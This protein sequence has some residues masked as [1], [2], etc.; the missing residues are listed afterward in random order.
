M[1]ITKSQQLL[2][3]VVTE[4]WENADFKKK[5][6]ADPVNAIEELTGEKL[7]IPEGKTFVVKDQTD[8]STVYI[9]IPAEQKM[10][11]VE[12]NDAQLEAVAGGF[13]GGPN[14]ETCTAPNPFNTIT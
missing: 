14:G 4:A 9:N 3:Q 12:L 5:L 1:E 2:Q 8:E 7:N 13:F 10:D 6:L 11:N